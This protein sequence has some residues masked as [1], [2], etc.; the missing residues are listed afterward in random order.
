MGVRLHTEQDSQVVAGLQLADLVAHTTG[1]M[2]LDSLGLIRKRIKMGEES[3]YPEESDMELGF[4]L[5]AS[6][7]YQ[8]FLGESLY[9]GDDDFVYTA[10]I[11]TEDT[12]LH[13]ASC[14]PS[15]LREAALS[16]FEA[17]HLGCI[18]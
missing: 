3:G 13:I 18:Y 8:F 6:L 12:A 9:P 10:T 1:I 17:M 15:R 5:W 4:A 11:K 2:L 14:S 7:R 16:R